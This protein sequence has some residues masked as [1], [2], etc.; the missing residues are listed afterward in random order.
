MIGYDT[1]VHYDKILCNMADAKIHNN[2]NNKFNARFVAV[3]ATSGA[4]P[5]T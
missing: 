5:M 1:Q 3:K 4:S 2:N